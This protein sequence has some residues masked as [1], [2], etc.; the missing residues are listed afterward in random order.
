MH[1]KKTRLR[2][3]KMLEEME[4]VNFICLHH[5]C[6]CLVMLYFAQI[7]HRLE[8]EVNDLKSRV[9]VFLKSKHNGDAVCEGK[10][11]AFSSKARTDN[12]NESYIEAYGGMHIGIPNDM[13]VYYNF[14]LFNGGKSYGADSIPLP[15]NHNYHRQYY[16]GNRQALN[17]YCD[18]SIYYQPNP[19]STSGD[20]YGR[21]SIPYVPNSKIQSNGIPGW[22]VYPCNGSIDLYGNVI[23]YANSNESHDLKW[24]PS[25]ICV[26]DDDRDTH[27][28]TLL[29]TI[30]HIDFKSTTTTSSSSGSSS[31]S[32][33]ENST[34]DNGVD[35][36]WSGNDNCGSDS[37]NNEDS[38]KLTS[39]P[40]SSEK[41]RSDSMCSFDDS[42]EKVTTLLGVLKQTPCTEIALV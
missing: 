29:E 25:S 23:A 18:H 40:S 17:G 3:K 6:F 41:A 4:M 21:L 16:Q 22:P 5:A 36:E 20:N 15:L 27:N 39:S 2:K 32:S 13:P 34:S 28:K 38:A 35:S 10:E 7:K 26:G 19:T 1:A 24:Y 37:T 9:Q 14:P 33:I 42:D 31:S 30:Q 12:T 8:C 11:M